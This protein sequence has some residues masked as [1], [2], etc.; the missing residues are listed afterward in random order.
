MVYDGVI[1]GKYV[2][3][4]SCTEEDAEFTLSLRKDPKLGK[5]FP[6]IDNTVEQ[7]TEWI[8]HQRA[9]EGDY[10]F[11]VRNKQGDR[12]GTISVYNIADGEG[13]SGRII[14]RSA[15]P[16]DA[17]E[18]QLL[19]ARFGFHTLGLKQ[20]KGFVFAENKRAIRFNKQFAARLI[21][22]EE[23]EH[24]RMVVRTETTRDE[25]EAIDRKISSLIY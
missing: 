16:F 17:S 7:Q 2:D 20:M 25:F 24:G 9:K 14:I 13:E 10:F 19:L 15:N 22:P 11:V 12:I 1:E 4:R 6:V 5:F 3:L 23:D 18:A 21:G 8:R